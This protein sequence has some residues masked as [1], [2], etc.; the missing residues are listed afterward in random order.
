MSTG[1]FILSVLLVLFAGL[2]LL[3]LSGASVYL[4]LG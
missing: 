4:S 2:I 3:G 1:S